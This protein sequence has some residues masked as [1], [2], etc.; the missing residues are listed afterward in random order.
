MQ[1][2][3]SVEVKEHQEEIIKPKPEQNLDGNQTDSITRE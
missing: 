2:L 1:E 3:P